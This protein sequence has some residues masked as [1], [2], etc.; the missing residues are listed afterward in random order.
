MGTFPAMTIHISHILLIFVRGDM[1][2]ETADEVIR[3]EVES[4]SA[5]RV[6]LEELEKGP[7]TGSQ[8]REKIRRDMIERMHRAG[9][10]DIDEDKVVVTDPKLYFNTRHLE[11]LGIIVS[12]RES[13]QR[14]FSIAPRAAPAVRRVLN[15]TRNTTVI[16]SVSNPEQVRPLVHW[17][18]QE[19]E[20]HFNRLRIVVEAARFAKGVS[21]D[22]TRHVPDG[23]TKRWEGI[24][25]ELPKE[26]VGYQDGGVQGDLMATYSHIEKILLEELPGH[27]VIF[28]LSTAPS[29]IGL[30]FCLLANDYAVTAIYIRRHRA[31]KTTLTH[32]IPG[33]G[34]L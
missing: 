7:R 21:K 20:A 8:L 27:N 26:V 1:F 18:T 29:L 9:K 5:R 25:D 2:W 32:Y 31:R 3:R 10:T 17:F 23:T 13:R 24:W 33:R 11:R 16:S 34:L 6:I 12:H 15:V 30:A 28:D 22:L 19:A 14:V 4:V